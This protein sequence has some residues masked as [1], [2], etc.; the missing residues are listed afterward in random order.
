MSL[1]RQARFYLAESDVLG[2]R[3]IVVAKSLADATGKSLTFYRDAL[4]VLEQQAVSGD[5]DIDFKIAE[6]EAGVTEL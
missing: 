6:V 5:V 3:W 4:S 2:K 1:E